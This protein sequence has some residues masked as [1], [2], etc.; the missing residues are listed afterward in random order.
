MAEMGW[1]GILIGEADGGSDF[2]YPALGVIL[3]QSGRTLAAS[4]LISTAL[5]GAPLIAACANETPRATVL[6]EVI[7]GN[8][9]LALALDETAR[10]TPDQITTTATADGDGFVISGEKTFVLDGHIADRLIV[11]ARTSGDARSRDGISLFLV[12][13]AAAGV[14][15][16]RTV[17]VDGRNAA[18]ITFANVA[19]PADALLGTR[20][21]AGAELEPILDGARAG[22]AAE[23]LGAGLEAFDRT[24]D[25]LKVR[26]Q[27][28]APIG[29]FQ[30]LKH[31]AAEMFCEIELAR[32]ATYAALDAMDAH[33]DDTAELASLAKTKACEMLELVSNE[34]V[35]MHG[36]IG[37]T[38]AADI[39]LFLKR[40]RVAQQCL[41]DALFHRNRYADLI[42]I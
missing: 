1:T 22:L 14:T 31:R 13:P 4:P 8:C 18:N 26:E 25:Y 34:A 12:D 38:D 27:F 20:D 17:M 2:G 39:G 5:I 32:S 35:Q 21:E 16:R 41:G 37:M 40:A 36:G 10:H 15:R 19:V 11:A 3:E 7:A 30:A 24:I 33:R 23:M 28:G 6:G 9:I 42:G 29:S